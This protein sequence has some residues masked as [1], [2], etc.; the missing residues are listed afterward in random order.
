MKSEEP[1]SSSVDIVHAFWNEVWNAHDPDAVDRFVVEDFV[2]IN[3]GN[4]IRGR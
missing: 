2:I 3:A 4:E 1:G